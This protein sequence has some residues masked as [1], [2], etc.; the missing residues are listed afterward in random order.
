MKYLIKKLLTLIITLLL[1]SFLSF[2]AFSV[3]P[4]DA[5][6]AKLGKD[7]TEEQ[8]TKMREE[9][10]LDDPLLIRY[11]NWL[12]GAVHG[13]FGES[14]QYDGIAVS[15]LLAERLPVTV[16]LAVVAMVIIVIFAVPL[17]ILCARFSGGWL[18]TVINQITQII[19][20]IPAF[21][22]GI[23]L[24]YILG[25]ILHVFSLVVSRFLIVCSSLF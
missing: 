5:A 19:M 24:T 20:A 2:A 9:M 25:L 4:G 8:L 16:L 10:G 13:D 22:L 7:A 15:E 21:V 18:D 12:Q 3:I 14:Y 17:G 6:L 11:S 1:I 23:L